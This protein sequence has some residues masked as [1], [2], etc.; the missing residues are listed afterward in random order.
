VVDTYKVVKAA[1]FVREDGETVVANGDTIDDPTP[2]ELATGCLE[3]LELS[4]APAVGVEPSQDGEELEELE[5]D[6]E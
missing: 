1:R 3:P 2:A 5:T 4:E 6:G